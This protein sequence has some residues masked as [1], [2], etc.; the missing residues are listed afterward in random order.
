MQDSIAPSS[1]GVGGLQG[2]MERTS[3]RRWTVKRALLL[4]L[5][6]AAALLI[7]AQAKPKKQ[8]AELPAVFDHAQYVRVEAE[9]GDS[10]TPGL[11]PEDREAI[12]DVEQGLHDWKRY[13]IAHKREDAELVF[14]VRKG[15]LA[16][17]TPR[18]MGGIGSRPQDR[19][20]GSQS[21]GSQGPIGQS[22]NAQDPFG[23]RSAGVGLGAEGGPADDML[24]VY[25][26][27]PAGALSGPIWTQS[28]KGGLE[29][30]GLQLLRRIRQEVD[31]AYPKN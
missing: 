28:L 21:P 27:N 18:V 15:R 5:V 3:G 6:G 22:P 29:M 14:V 7:S 4:V 30:P 31:A 25:M 8:K 10:F 23:D 11:Y 24:S 17:V 12:Y 1:A 9:G 19:N 26:V 20:P 16:S 2:A 13:T